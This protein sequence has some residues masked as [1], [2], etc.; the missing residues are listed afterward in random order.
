MCALKPQVSGTISE[1][2]L[3]TTCMSQGLA[4]EGGGRYT[5]AIGY[6]ISL[7][8]LLSGLEIKIQ[9]THTAI[10]LT[11]D[12]HSRVHFV[13]SGTSILEGPNINGRII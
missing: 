13:V 9:A 10:A 2:R 7:Q 5:Q 1:E 8:G 3:R 4:V 11:P 6:T 12:K